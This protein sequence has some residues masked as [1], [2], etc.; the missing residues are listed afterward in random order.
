[1]VLLFAFATSIA[2]PARAEPSPADVESARALYVQGL[3]LRDQGDLS[4]SLAR[5][6]AAQALA[7]TPITTL[8]LGR[9]RSMMGQLIEARDALT[10]VDRIPVRPDESPKAASAREE[11]RALAEQLRRRIPSLR[12]TFS[13]TPE[14]TPKIT[15]DG[16][17]IPPE[18]AA[19]PRKLNPGPHEVVAELGASRGTAKVI[20]REGLEET[21]TLTLSAGDAER[22]PPAPVPSA[23]APGPQPP[24][25]S[26]APRPGALFYTGLALTGVGLAVGGTTGILAL[27]KKSDLDDMCSG[28]RCPRTAQDELDQAH[29][30]TTLSTVGFIAAGVGAVVTIVALL[31]MDSGVPNSSKAVSWRR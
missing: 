2:L 22:P 12:V 27:S 20:L 18:A 30:M 19:V 4:T 16:T 21:V 15:V 17:P 29:T 3:Q 31:T 14:S 25:T 5:F 1:L 28:T 9:A 13:P 8:E 26:E 11:A 24:P 23:P 6:Q 7:P 10:A